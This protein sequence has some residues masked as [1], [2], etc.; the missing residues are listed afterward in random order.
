MD[1]CLG[2]CWATDGSPDTVA[3]I[4]QNTAGQGHMAIPHTR[5]MPPL[6]DSA[7]RRNL[8]YMA[9][10][11][12]T[13]GIERF[14]RDLRSAGNRRTG[15]R[16]SGEQSAPHDRRDGQDRRRSD[17]RD[18]MYERFS[19]VVTATIQR[20]VMDA[21]MAVACPECGGHL[22]MG[23]PSQREDMLARRI[24]CTRCGRVAFIRDDLVSD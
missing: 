7:F 3:V 16:R 13:S 14:L 11:H 17:R 10:K 20:M 21:A 22:M 2:F 18:S 12:T 4:Y 5:Y 9:L 24:Q 8:L 6:A 23:P 19:L 1:R 15:D